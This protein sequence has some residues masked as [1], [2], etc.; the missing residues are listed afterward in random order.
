MSL[1]QN[2][3]TIR[4]HASI[5]PHFSRDGPLETIMSRPI[6][7]VEKLSKAYRLGE[8]VHVH[9]TLMSAAV[10]NLLNPMR[11]L[12]RLRR[13]TTFREDDDS[14]DVLWALR[15]VSFEIN[16]GDVIG[17]IGRNG[18]GKSTLLKIL[19][20]ITEPTSG[21]AVIRGRVSSLL[22]VGTGFHQELSGRDNIYMNGTVLGMKKREIDRKFDEIVDFS[23]VERFLDTP[24]KRYSS[25][26][27]VRLAFAVAAHLEP[28]VLIVDEVLA[29]GD[30]E[31][32]RKCLGKMSEVARGG[33]TILFVSH[34]MAAVENLC[35]KAILLGGG[36]VVCIGEVGY[37]ISLYAEQLD[38]DST[39]LS[40]A[41]RLSHLHGTAIRLV[42]IHQPCHVYSFG[43]TIVFHIVYDVRAPQERLRFGFTICD[44]FESPLMSGFSNEDVPSSKKG[45]MTCS[46]GLRD[47]RLAPGRYTLNLSLGVGDILSYR[48]EFDIVK[49]ATS[50]IVSERS[51]GH[52]AVTWSPGFGHVHVPTTVCTVKVIEACC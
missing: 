49:Q 23:G 34:N 13:L 26:M 52:G 28:E 45:R 39:D 30:A 29:V 46:L 27:Q 36:K 11:N 17:V 31:F 10:S 20:R 6:I 14:S 9:D 33:R 40:A 24:V 16:Q 42:S 41:P 19:S 35:S 2:N 5:T 21:R 48:Q 37:V 18:A 50:F 1:V 15:D 8:R 12:N 47:V 32:Q 25:G 3:K 44:A 22:E 4:L 51:E 38:Q 7:Q 43:E